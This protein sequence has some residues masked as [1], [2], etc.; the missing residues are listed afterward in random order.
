MANIAFSTH[1]FCRKWAGEKSEMQPPL[2][3]TRLEYTL[4]ILG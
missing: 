2:A 3:S 1:P 4:T